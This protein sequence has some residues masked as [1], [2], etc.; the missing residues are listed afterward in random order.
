M[1]WNV[2]IISSP[3]WISAAILWQG[4]SIAPKT[5][6]H[7]WT[8]I[9]IGNSNTW[10]ATIIRS[11]H[12]ISVHA[13]RWCNC[14]ATQTGRT[15]MPST[16]DSLTQW[17]ECI[18][19]TGH[20][21]GYR[22]IREW[23]T[24]RMQRQAGRRC[25]QERVDYTN[26]E[27]LLVWTLPEYHQL[28]YYWRKHQWQPRLDLR[29]RRPEATEPPIGFQHHENTQREDCQ[30]DSLTLRTSWQYPVFLNGRP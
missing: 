6:S 21:V 10:F 2:L 16:I 8:W 22:H 28:A 19:N 20:P 15:V 7:R 27:W 4:R 13:P 9:T 17:Q 29:H 1:Y 23:R 25:P 30:S 11:H 14:V 24:E 26:M 12:W 18:G 5:W 3:L